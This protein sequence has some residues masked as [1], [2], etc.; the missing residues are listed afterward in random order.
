MSVHRERE[1]RER[2]KK[3][4]ERERGE[5]ERREMC[6]YYVLRV[7]AQT[8]SVIVDNTSDLYELIKLITDN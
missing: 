2:E 1:R 4:R 7:R 8:M 6:T 3:R 5:R